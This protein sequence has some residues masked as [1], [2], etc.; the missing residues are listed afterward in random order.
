MAG[1]LTVGV[2][3]GLLPCGVDALAE[4]PGELD[5]PFTT[6]ARDLVPRVIQ[7]PRDRAQLLDVVFHVNRDH[8]CPAVVACRERVGKPADNRGRPRH[9]A[10]VGKVVVFPR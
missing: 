5:P 9:V 2:P 10:L 8:R 4:K 1:C 6:R 3:V 7:C